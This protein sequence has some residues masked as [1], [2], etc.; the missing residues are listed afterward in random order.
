MASEKKTKPPE[1]G[2]YVFTTVLAFFGLWCLYDG[3]FTTDPD[4]REHLLFNRI[5]A[6]VL[7]PWALID[8]FRTRKR[9]KKYAVEQE[10]LK[11]KDDTETE[12]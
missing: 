1:I 12:E 6:G 10:Q 7:L 3:F 8:F 9:E 4:M 11:K 5:T 2:P